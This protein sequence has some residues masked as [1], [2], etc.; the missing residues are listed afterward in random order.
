MGPGTDEKHGA[1]AGLWARAVAVLGASGV[2]TIAFA[3]DFGLRM[4]V[5][6]REGTMPVVLDLSRPMGITFA[7]LIILTTTTLVLHI[8]SR[9]RWE[10]HQSAQAAE[11]GALQEKLG[12]AE[13]FMAGERHVVVAWG[14]ASGEAEIVGDIGLI[15]DAGAPRRIL[16]FSQWLKGPDTKRLE[17]AVERLKLR[18]EGFSLTLEGSTGKRL[19]VD[20]RAVTGR[21]VMRIRDVTGDQ[22]ERVRAEEQSGKLTGEIAAL[23]AVLDAVPQPVWLRYPDGRLAW[24]NR[25][26]AE[27]VDCRQPHEAISRG[28]ELIDKPFR[29]RMAVENAT[30][31]FL[32]RFPAILAGKR[33]L[34]DVVDVRTPFG[35][36]GLASNV[37]EI[38]QLKAQL[39]AEMAT[40][41]RTLNELPIAVAV[42][43]RNRQMRFNNA[44]YQKLWQLDPA[45]LARQPGDGEI[46]DR[47]RT[48]KQLPEQVDF[49]GWK[50]SLLDGYQRT[51]VTEHIWHLPDGRMLRVVAS[52]TPDGGISYIYDD[53]TERMTLEAQFKALSR[54]QNE[55]LDSLKEGVAVFGSDGRLKLANA[56]FGQM[57]AIHPEALQGNPHIDELARRCK[58][59]TDSKIWIHLREAVTGLRDTRES[60]KQRETRADGAVIDCATQPLPDGATLVT[61]ADVT[62]SVNAEH[63]LQEKNEALETAAKVKNAFIQNVSYEL[64]TPLQNVTL[65]V[66]M[67]EA[68]IAGTLSPKQREYVNAATQSADALLTLMNDIF[69]L[70]SLDAGVLELKTEEVTPA[71]EIAAVQAALMDRLAEARLTLEIHAP[72]ETGLFRADAQR[73]RQVLFH[74]VANAIAF[75]APGGTI[76][77]SAKREP[78]HM[79][80]TVRDQGRGIPAEALAR[81]F[82]RFE[83]HGEGSRRGVGLGLSMVKAF[84]ELH[85]GDVGVHSEQG[86]GTTVTCRFPLGMATGTP[87][88]DAS[89]AA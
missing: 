44:A 27:A 84:M 16:G 19:E 6:T 47:L 12:Q 78:S 85:G 11:I 24:V 20:G 71:T 4:S 5:L 3:N 10:K 82:E 76:S 17:E 67:L 42:F 37:S 66:G 74:L 64:R 70:A 48:G 22:L 63:F 40:H 62:A 30:K 56:A 35:S 75:S 43:D 34:M 72:P 2:P 38:E 60:M 14:H 15:L 52:P 88:S 1:R 50:N 53:M 58:L 86:F 45:F 83:S 32:G 25:S 51:E 29:E 89:K 18:G 41:V 28:V 31:P 9:Q 26:Y 33:V 7:G 59:A 49:R 69:D 73:I 77:V 13:I 36:G 87:E 61:F 65:A 79:L 54:V 80:L 39:E 68:E 57:W 46:L 23:H 81:I 21:A 55:T 8:V